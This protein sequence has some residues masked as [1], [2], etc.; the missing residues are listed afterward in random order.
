MPSRARRATEGGVNPRKR[1]SQAYGFTKNLRKTRLGESLVAPP[2]SFFEIVDVGFVEGL[3]PTGGGILAGK[4]PIAARDLDGGVKFVD[5][6]EEDDQLS[7]PVVHFWADHGGDFFGEGFLIKAVVEPGHVVFHGLRRD[8]G[9]FAAILV[10]LGE[11]VG[12]PG[13][14]EQ[15]NRG[16][17]GDELT[18]LRHVDTVAVGVADLGSSGGDDDAVGL[19]AGKDVDNRFAEGSSPDDGVVDAD[20]IVAFLDGPVGDVVNMGDQVGAVFLLTDECAQFDVLVGHFLRAGP[21]AKN[22][23]IKEVLVEGSFPG[24]LEDRLLDGLTAVLTQPLH[25]PVEADFR[26]VGDVT[27]DGAVE[28]TINRFKDFWN[29]VPSEGLSFPVDLSIVAAGKVD[30]FEGTILKFPRFAE[31]A[32]V[33]AAIGLDHQD[34]TRIKGLNLIVILLKDGHQRGAL[35]GHGQNFIVFKVKERPYSPGVAEGEQV[36]VAEK[37]PDGIATVPGLRGLLEN[38]RRIDILGNPAGV[39]DSVQSLGVP[40][41][42]EEAVVFLVEMEADLFE[43]GLSVRIEDGMLAAGDQLLVERTGIGHVEV[44][45]QHEIAHGPVAFAKIGVAALLGVAPG[46]SVAEMSHHGF[47]G[48]GEAVLDGGDELRK[49]LPPLDQ[50]FVLGDEVFKNAIKGVGLNAALAKHVGLSRRHVQFDGSDA[51]PV[52]AAVVLLLHE[53]EDAVKT[54]QGSLVFLLVVAEGTLEPHQSHAAFVLD[55][56]AHGKVDLRLSFTIVRPA[57]ARPQWPPGTPGRRR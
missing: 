37:T 2:A 3:V 17:E 28:L 6:L 52:L 55:G 25:H 42:V 32:L 43:N 49:H 4:V 13:V 34:G 15:F 11:Q 44:S 53:E 12:L 57:S 36:A 19:E 9:L 8:M 22:H 51:R 30:P 39:L 21:V 45:C 47:G 27:E 29:Q 48:E 5:F 10:D 24:P 20:Q 26:G 33:S 7:V 46:S 23:L 18:Q 31:G 14:A 38:P 54:P 56:V 40:E 16:L 50:R 1:R 41:L 35:R